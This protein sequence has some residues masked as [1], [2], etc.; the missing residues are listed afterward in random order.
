[1]IMFIRRNPDNPLKN[2]RYSK[3]RSFDYLDS[4]SEQ[5]RVDILGLAVSKDRKRWLP[6]MEK[7]GFKMLSNQPKTAKKV[8]K[9]L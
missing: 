7:K 1:M 2:G 3:Q 9:E 5:K 4:L 8:I 6:T